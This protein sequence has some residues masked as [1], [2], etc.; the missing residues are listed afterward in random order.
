MSMARDLV[1]SFAVK[2]ARKAEKEGIPY[3]GSPIEP[4]SH[5]DDYL[6]GLLNRVEDDRAHRE[7]EKLRER[8][9]KFA[10]SDSDL[11]AGGMAAATRAAA[12]SI[13]PY[14]FRD[15]QLVRK[16]DGKSITL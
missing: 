12:D 4:A 10:D 11:V 6:S 15:G 5:D 13:D 14:E 9:N 8:A 3:N 1:Y 7:A 2:L 16:S